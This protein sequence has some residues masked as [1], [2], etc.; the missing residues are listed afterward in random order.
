MKLYFYPGACSMAVHIVLREADYRFDLD[1]V[2]LMTKQTEG[3]EDYARVNP[4]GYVP[5]LR[6]D[7][8]EV[9]TEAAAIMQYLADN[10][11]AAGLAPKPGTREH[12]RL[13]EWLNF[14]ATE[15]H[16][17]LG[18][19]FNPAITPE[20][21]ADRIAQFERYCDFLVDALADRPYLLGENFSIA[22][23]YLFTVLGWT[24]LFQIDLGRWPALQSYVGRIAAR[25]MVREAMRAE[26][27]DA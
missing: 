7:D 13:I 8:G 25:P 18:A 9:L 14:I 12:Y 23:A 6:L 10:K 1:R 26:G 27:L 17:S 20:W 3:G 19:L 5:A 24:G 2:D 16:K 22:D 21:K 15:I 11:P 4:K